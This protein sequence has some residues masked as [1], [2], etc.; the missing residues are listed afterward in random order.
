MQ[1][2]LFTVTTFFFLVNFQR[3]LWEP[4]HHSV[5]ATVPDPATL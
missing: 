2:E 3:P 1:E 5:M 4:A